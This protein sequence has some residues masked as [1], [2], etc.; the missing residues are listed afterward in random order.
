[1]RK[2]P[3]PQ[4]LIQIRVGTTNEA[5]LQAVEAMFGKAFGNVNVEGYEVDSDIAAQPMTDE[6][7]IQGALN[8]ARAAQTISPAADY[9]VGMEGTL[10]PVGEFFF[11][12]GW[13]AVIDQSGT[14][15]LGHSAGVRIPDTIARQVQKGHELGPLIRDL[16]GDNDNVIRHSLG[17]NGV[18]TGGLYT[19][20]DEFEDATACALVPFISQLAS[21]TRQ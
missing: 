13:V 10:A 4:K 16:H 7:A 6:E 12:R 21:V 19:R 15:G 3:V 18:L 2:L 9:C 20:V 5:K 11:L 17:T 8:R 14:V 1:M